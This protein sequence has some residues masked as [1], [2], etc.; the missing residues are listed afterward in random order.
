MK[1][2]PDV[3]EHLGHE[4]DS[5]ERVAAVASFTR[6]SAGGRTST[7][8]PGRKPRLRIALS[9]ASQSCGAS[10][11]KASGGKRVN[12]PARAWRVRA[13]ARTA[14]PLEWQNEE[15]KPPDRGHPHVFD[16]LTEHL[17]SQDRVD[18]TVG[19][20]TRNRSRWLREAIESVL[21]QSYDNFEL[22]VSDNAS[23]DDTSAVVGSFHDARLK[24]AP[25]EQN[26]GMTGNLNRLIG[27]CQ[28][29][30]LV[31]LCSSS[32]LRSRSSIPDASRH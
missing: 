25:L 9:I 14:D 18:V 3:L 29:E 24:Y 21:A 2:L 28:T 10:S 31:L 11:A 22:I 1:R 20:P 12:P 23:T 32:T 4:R 15:C 19:I 13:S 27:L 17:K 26:V 6:I 7:T 5:L 8:S 30:F 16:H